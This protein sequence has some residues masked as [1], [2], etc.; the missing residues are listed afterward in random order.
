MRYVVYNK[1]TGQIVRTYRKMLAE[2][3]EAVPAEESDILSD[4]PPGLT[5]DDVSVIAL[6]EV[7]F[8]RGKT[9]R[10]DLAT[11]EIVGKAKKT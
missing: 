1:K 6:K 11:G 9:Y 5:K 4:L 2:S 7:S 8:E 10:V 3:G